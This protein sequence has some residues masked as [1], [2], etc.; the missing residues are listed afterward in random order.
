MDRATLL[1]RAT[2]L[3]I[4][5]S[6][7]AKLAAAPPVAPAAEVEVIESYAWLRYSNDAGPLTPWVKVPIEQIEDA[8]RRKLIVRPSERAMRNGESFQL[9]MP[10]AIA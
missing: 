8:Y 7:L 4:G 6:I 10:L 5:P 2:A 3:L 9:R 1:R